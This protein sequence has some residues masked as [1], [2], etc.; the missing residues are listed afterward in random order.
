MKS[1][2][3][4]GL[5]LVAIIFSSTPVVHAASTPVSDNRTK[6]TRGVKNTCYTVNYNA[7]AYTSKINAAAKSWASLDNPIKN[8]AVA[9]TKG[10]HIDFYAYTTANNAYLTDGIIAYTMYYDDK[11]NVIHMTSDTSGPVKDY[12]YTDIVINKSNNQYVTQGVIAHEMGHAYGLVHLNNVG[13]IMWPYGNSMQV[14]TPQSMDNQ[15]I[16]ILY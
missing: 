15:A 2:V 12:Y 9:S 3:L 11:A 4:L 5:L 16:N 10:S 14:S 13:S 8:T 6:F 1:K 7:S